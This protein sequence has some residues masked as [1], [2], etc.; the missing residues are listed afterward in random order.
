MADETS[1]GRSAS[2]DTLKCRVV[3]AARAQRANWC[4]FLSLAKFSGIYGGSGTSGPVVHGGTHSSR[5][6]QSLLSR[7]QAEFTSHLRNLVSH[8]P[9]AQADRSST[10][11]HWPGSTETSI[12]TGRAGRS[13]LVGTGRI[14]WPATRAS[15]HR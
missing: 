1:A 15:R 2:G 8:G 3:E 9:T 13:V 4:A 7:T 11:A 5:S 14:V 10:R 12:M 6:R